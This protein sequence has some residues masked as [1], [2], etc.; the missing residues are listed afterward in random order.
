MNE[1][2]L[3]PLPLTN[4]EAALLADDRPAYPMTAFYRLRFNGFLEIAAFQSALETVTRRHPFLRAVISRN[5]LGQL[6]WKLHPNCQPKILRQARLTPSGFPHMT[7]LDP[8]QEAGFRWWVLERDGGHDVIAQGHHCSIDG[9]G[10]NTVIED[11]LVSYA[12]QCAQNSAATLRHLDAQR[13]LR[14]GAP[15]LS[16]SKNFMVALKQI[17]GLTG[18]HEFLGRSPVP[19]MGKYHTTSLS[20]TTHDEFP[21]IISQKFDLNETEKIKTA[22][23]SSKVTMN[24][25]L[26]RDLF[27]AI[28]VWRKKRG[29][30]HNG[31]WL[32]IAIPIN[33]RGAADTN[34]PMSNSVSM[35]F[36][37]RQAVDFED[38]NRLLMSIHDQ[39]ALIKQF[40]LEYTYILSLGMTRLV[41]GLMPRIMQTDR[42]QSTT[43]LSNLG[44]VLGQVPLPNQ[45]G[46]L[47]CG[48]VVLESVDI[49][50]VLRLHTNA[51]FLI[52]NYAGRLRLT[53]Q[54]DPRVMTAD[55]AKDLLDAYVRQIRGTLSVV[56]NA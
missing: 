11:L 24:M 56:G 36:A 48:N 55:Q 41:P 8:R 30:G 17:R 2:N 21:A 10:I 13:L 7:Y 9:A 35:I 14:R 34:M 5:W 27:L 40:E 23:K 15:K 1:E 33:L 50:S 38:E 22:A 16:A 25:L 43:Y 52:Y 12:N 18:V 44:V 19:L 53:L 26:L 32:R 45:D 4:F 49:A 51:G 20:T 31:D 54:Y 3:F 47:V 28:N 6:A 37:D 29:I 39:L 42:C 46:R